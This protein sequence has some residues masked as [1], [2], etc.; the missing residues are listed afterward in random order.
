MNI[1]LTLN[2]KSFQISVQSNFLLIINIYFRYFDI[3]YKCV[4]C[5]WTIRSLEKVLK[6]LLRYDDRIRGGLKKGN[7]FEWFNELQTLSSCKRVHVHDF[8]SNVEYS[9]GFHPST[10]I[11][12]IL[13]EIANKIVGK[14]IIIDNN[15]KTVD[16]SKDF[17][18]YFVSEIYY[19]LI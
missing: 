15:G 13:N 1:K 14:Y 19:I 18:H 2:E 8:S 9:F 7:S 12:L 11:S 6:L 16:G 17:Y 4:I 5:S 10:N 3:N